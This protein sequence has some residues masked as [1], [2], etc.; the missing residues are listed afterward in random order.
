M[1]R[2][3]P[4]TSVAKNLLQSPILV[5]HTG[6]VSH[7]HFNPTAPHSIAASA[8][9]GVQIYMPKSSTKQK[10][11]SRFKDVAYCPQFRGDRRRRF[12]LCFFSG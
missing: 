1:R 10:T 11:I 3:R 12:C 2:K 8:S 6:P 4:L 7:V 9:A 5:R